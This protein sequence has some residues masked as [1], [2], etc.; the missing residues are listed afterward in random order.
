[1]QNQHN[2]HIREQKTECTPQEDAL[3]NSLPKHGYSTVSMCAGT[4]MGHVN[5]YARTFAG[6]VFVRSDKRTYIRMSLHA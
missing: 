1:M 2:T 3:S 5:A 6:S 4:N